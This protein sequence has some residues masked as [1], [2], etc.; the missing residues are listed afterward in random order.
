V[1]AAL[2]ACQRP[3]EVTQYQCTGPLSA[4]VRWRDELEAARLYGGRA[5]TADDAA[6][7][8]KTRMEATVSELAGR[9][10]ACEDTWRMGLWSEP[11]NPGARL[12][13]E[14]IR[15]LLGL[16]PQRYPEPAVGIAGQST[17]GLP[18]RQ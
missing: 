2:L 9:R 8:E 14:A 13:D 5:V 17:S 11:D 10:G 6:A 12:R 7:Q 18:A 1:I 15:R 3:V 16:E 4:L